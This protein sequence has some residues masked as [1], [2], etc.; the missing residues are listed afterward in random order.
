MQLFFYHISTLTGAF[1]DHTK[2]IDNRV[3]EH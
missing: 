3:I 1:T 2:K